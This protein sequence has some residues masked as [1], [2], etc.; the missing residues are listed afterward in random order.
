MRSRTA[1]TN[2]RK[3]ASSSTTRIVLP[4]FTYC[5]PV[6]LYRG[7]PPQGKGVLRFFNAP[8]P[9]RDGAFGAGEVRVN[10]RFCGDFPPPSLLVRESGEGGDG[11]APPVEGVLAK[12]GRESG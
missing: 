1:V 12:K 4:L 8:C 11:F 5:P 2:E 7:C 3:P 9:V 10:A 6:Q